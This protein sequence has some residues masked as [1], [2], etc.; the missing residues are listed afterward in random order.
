LPIIAAVVGGLSVVALLASFFAVFQL[1]R[2]GDTNTISKRPATGTLTPAASSPSAQP[3]ETATLAPSPTTAPRQ[4]VRITQN[5]D[6]RPLCVEDPKPYS[7]KLTNNGSSSAN[8]SVVFPVAPTVAQQAKQITGSASPPM[9]PHSLTSASPVWGVATPANGTLAAGQTASFS[10]NV[11]WGMPCGGTTYRATVKVGG[12]TDLP[13]TYAGTG[14]ARYSNIVVT[15]NQNYTESCPGGVAPP[16]P[17][18]VSLKNTGNYR[19]YI[20]FIIG[21]TTPLGDPWV[22]PVPNPSSSWIEGNGTMTLTMS[23]HSW[24]ACNGHTYNVR[25]QANSGTGQMQEISLSDTVN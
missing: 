17:Y 10:I 9:S 22:I 21:E 20:S 13:L 19:A 24:I 7:V 6:V 3:E 11:L 16:P 8:W 12:Q 4:G 15:A 14:P 23:P 5:Q 18:T 1:V 25:M 2:A